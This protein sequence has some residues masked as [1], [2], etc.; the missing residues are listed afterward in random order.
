MAKKSSKATKGGTGVIVGRFQVFELSKIHRKIIDAVRRRHKRTIVFL[1]TNPAPSNRNPLEWVFRWNMF[2]EV[3]GDKVEVAEMPDLP[4]DRIWSQELDR[5]IMELK[6]EGDVIVYGS[7]LDFISA[8]SGRYKTK[9][10]EPSQAEYEE[11]MSFDLISNFRDFR[12]GVMFGVLRRFPSVYATVDVGVF[13]NNKKELLLARKANETRWRLPGGFSDPDD[14][15]FEDA[16][17]RELGEECGDL[18][19]ADLEYLGSCRI[20]DWRYRGSW[21]SIITHLYVCQW[22]AGE[23]S[24]GDDIGEVRWFDVS[25]ITPE[26]F[27]HEH[28][29]LWGIL[30]DYINEEATE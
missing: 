1:T 4:D 29:P 8:Y 3:Y 9:A 15:S 27:V 7:E 22:E 12:A 23:P 30:E 21:D 18:D 25:K 2:E 26:Q 17:M 5:R 28:R 20:D 16:A 11:E 19:L 14:L 24:P 10:L 6:P 13:R